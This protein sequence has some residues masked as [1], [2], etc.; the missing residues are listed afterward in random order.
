VG[1]IINDSTPFRDY[2]RLRIYLSARQ[3]LRSV[4]ADV[5]DVRGTA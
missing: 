5:G 4:S 3:R 1:R 2:L